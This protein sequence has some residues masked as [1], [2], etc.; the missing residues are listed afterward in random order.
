MNFP[1]SMSFLTVKV[2]KESLTFFVDDAVTSEGKNKELGDH[3]YLIRKIINT[4]SV[5]DVS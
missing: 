1:M 2:R 4:S 5:P 3:I